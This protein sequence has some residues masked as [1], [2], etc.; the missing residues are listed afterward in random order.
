MSGFTSPEFIDPTY[1]Y[2]AEISA[3]PDGGSNMTQSYN[4]Q[5]VTY[6]GNGGQ[7]PSQ[8]QLNYPTMPN[9][10]IATSNNGGYNFNASDPQINARNPN[11]LPYQRKSVAEL[12]NK[13]ERE[14]ATQQPT[15]AKAM[16][17]N[18]MAGPENAVRPISF[19]G[20]SSSAGDTAQAMPAPRASDP[21]PQSPPYLFAQQAQPPF[22]QSSAPALDIQIAPQFQ[23]PA[24]TAAVCY[25]TQPLATNVNYQPQS[26]ASY[27]FQQ[28]QSLAGPLANQP[29]QPA[30][31]NYQQ[32]P[33]VGSYSNQSQA[34]SQAY[35]N[36]LDQPAN[37]VNSGSASN[38]QLQGQFGTQMQPI[39]FQMCVNHYYSYKYTA[40]TRIF[41]FH[42]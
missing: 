34:Q 18:Y 29:Q 12:S 5:P 32:Q 16:P 22:A 41:F 38:M 19:R 31:F 40:C 13:F 26:Q 3:C 15:A 42:L 1:S 9:P 6:N 23:A 37:F 14:V 35:M 10:N 2:P 8:Q 20:V 27:T 17:F 11:S 4:N 33:R 24:P 21:S 25:Q 7:Y 36:N 39:D 28:Q 30:A